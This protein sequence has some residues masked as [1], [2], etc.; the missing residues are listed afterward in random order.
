VEIV[1]SAETVL[2]PDD[3]GSLASRRGAIPE[4]GARLVGPDG[5]T[6]DLP[7]EVFEALR[8]V[9]QAL[10]HGQAVTIAAH[11]TELT[12]GQAAEMLGVSRPTLVKLLDTGQVPCTQ[13]GRHRRVQVADVLAYRQ[14]RS[15]E[16][17]SGLAA[18]VAISEDLGLY[19]EQMPMTRR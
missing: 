9:V 13:P 17:A 5:T 19:D 2:P 11:G 10:Q 12:T 7:A 4:Q 6:T 18:M 16:R 8:G 3:P 14:R 1:V 15:E